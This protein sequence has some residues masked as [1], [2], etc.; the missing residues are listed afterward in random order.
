MSVCGRRPGDVIKVFCMI[1]FLDEVPG[2]EASRLDKTSDLKE[3]NSSRM[4]G[5]VA[6]STFFFW[7]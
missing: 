4:K 3:P 2:Q 1:F 5:R 6:V 7:I